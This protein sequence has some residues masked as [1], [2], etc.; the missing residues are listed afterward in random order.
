VDE[1]DKSTSIA[2]QVASP[3]SK[4]LCPKLLLPIKAF[5]Q[6]GEVKPLSEVWGVVFSKGEKIYSRID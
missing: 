4:R 3:G 6:S 1:R 5:G 2:F